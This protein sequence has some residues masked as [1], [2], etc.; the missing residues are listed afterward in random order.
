MRGYVVMG[1]LA[2]LA[3]LAAADSV[4]PALDCPRGSDIVVKA[5][6][7]E[8]DPFHY[9][10]M[11][12]NN[13]KEP[14]LEVTIGRGEGRDDWWEEGD[15][16]WASATVP[17]TFGTPRG[18]KARIVRGEE[19]RLE[20][21]SEIRGLFSY[22]W[23]VDDQFEWRPDELGQGRGAGIQPGRSLSGFSVQLP[24]PEQSRFTQRFSWIARGIGDPGIFGLTDKQRLKLQPDLRNVRFI[25]GDGNRC[26]Q[27]GDV[28]AD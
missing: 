4:T 28:Q 16:E 21:E 9:A 6:R 2:T 5:I 3:S 11:V 7:F 17:I 8:G 1:L 15:I 25:A 19:K 18:W 12:T 24:T 10:F 23:S 22:E 13:S 27:L 14:I 20:S 26:L